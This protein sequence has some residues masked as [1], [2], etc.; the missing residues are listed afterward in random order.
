MA[1]ETNYAKSGTQPTGCPSWDNMGNS[2]DLPPFFRPTEEMKRTG[3]EVTFLVDGPRKETENNFD[4]NARDL[5]FDISYQGKEMTWTICQISLLSEL[6][7]HSPLKDKTLVICLVPVT[8]EFR[9]KRPKYK[10]SERY[11]VAETEFNSLIEEQVVEDLS[12]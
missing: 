6:K 8:E 5:W 9:R 11:Q 4:S 2:G 10:G 12:V 3:F 1:N 7:K